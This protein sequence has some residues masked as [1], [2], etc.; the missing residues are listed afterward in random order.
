MSIS[1][2]NQ[3]LDRLKDFE[4]KPAMCLPIV[5]EAVAAGEDFFRTLMALGASTI[6][7]SSTWEPSAVTIRARTPGSLRF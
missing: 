2:K 1:L 3:L 4:A 6:R 5:I 7:K